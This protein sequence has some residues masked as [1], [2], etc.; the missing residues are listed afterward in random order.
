MSVAVRSPE[1]DICAALAEMADGF[2]IEGQALPG[3]SS[4]HEK[5]SWWQRKLTS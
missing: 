5:P 4:R 1:E 2:G 3:Q